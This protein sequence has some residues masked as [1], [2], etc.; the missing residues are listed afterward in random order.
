[1]K[2]LIA[3]NGGPRKDQNT[4]KLLQQMLQG[5]RDAGSEETKL[6]HLYDLQFHDCY[7]CFACKRLGAPTFGK[8]AYRDGLT[9]LL[10][11]IREEADGLIVGS[12]IYFSDVTGE[13]RAFLNRLVFPYLAYSPARVSLFPRTIP[14]A[15]VATGNAKS[16]TYFR[17]V[18]ESPRDVCR[19]FLGP[20]RLL[21][22][23]DTWQFSDYS[24]YA[25]SMFDPAHK[26]EVLE[27]EFPKKLEEAYQLG[28]A[29]VLQADWADDAS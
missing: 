18:T 1:M 3:V 14:T 22:A 9:P 11:E 10:D 20:C 16:E 12:P 15:V 6:V 8:C 24:K 19:R 2:K 29:M 28:R 7:S 4:A 27:K 13:T 5:A 17:Q 23:G 25:S 21:F 26:K